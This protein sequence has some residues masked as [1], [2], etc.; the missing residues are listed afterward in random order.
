MKHFFSM[1]LQVVINC[2]AL[3][4]SGAHPKESHLIG[5]GHSLDFWIGNYSSGESNVWPHLRTT[6]LTLPLKVWSTRQQLQ[7]HQEAY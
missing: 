4:F 2:E 5:Q 6:D 1:W 7:T 3:L